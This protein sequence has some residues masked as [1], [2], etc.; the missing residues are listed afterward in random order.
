MHPL[1]TLLT[2]AATFAGSQ[3]TITFVPLA[4]QRGQADCA[5]SLS[6]GRICRVQRQRGP[7]EL[8]ARLAAGTPV[9]LEGD[10]LSFVWEGPAESVEL[11]GG[12]QLPMSRLGGTDL[13]TLTVR[14]PKLERALVSY[15]FIPMG[16]AIEPVRRFTPRFWRGPLAPAAPD[17]ASVLQGRLVED[18]IASRFLPGP[19][20]V[21]VYLPPERAGAPIAAVVYAGD[22]HAVASLARIVDTMVTSG[23]LPRMMLVGLHADP[24]PGSPSAPDGR[25]LEYLSG[26][27]DSTRFLA[28]ERFFLEEVMPWAERTWGA[29]AA[30]ERR[31]AF[32][33]SNSAAFAIDMGLRHPE[34]IG[35]VLGFSPAG[36][37]AAV[38]VAPMPAPAF[39]L[40]GGL[41]E[42]A[43]QSLRYPLTVATAQA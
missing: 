21:T 40:L 8:R 4:A 41:Y 23:R 27:G 11:S 31:A 26:L 6:A 17:T 22:G 36:R 19:R 5:D 1:T 12:I 14:A 43:F 37:R 18:T 13:W 30:R 15:F 25:T 34:L 38:P 29:P 32:G 9:W 42:P 16:P 28:H 24:T 10:E 2:A 3:D 39:Y 35:H 20:P 33:F 7:G